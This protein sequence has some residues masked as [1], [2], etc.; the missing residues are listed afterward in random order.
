MKQSTIIQEAHAGRRI[1]W[2]ISETTRMSAAVFS[3]WGKGGGGGPF[4][5]QV[6]LHT[7]EASLW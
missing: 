2:R 4:L 3:S 6:K 1:P 5:V 7:R